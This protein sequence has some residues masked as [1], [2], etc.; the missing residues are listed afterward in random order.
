MFSLLSERSGDWKEEDGGSARLDKE[1][2]DFE[3]KMVYEF[4]CGVLE[5]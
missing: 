2:M 4:I 3:V 1:I 5:T